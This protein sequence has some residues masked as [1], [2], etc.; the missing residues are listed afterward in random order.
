MNT[1]AGSRLADPRQIGLPRLPD[2]WMTLHEQYG[3]MFCF[4]FFQVEF[5][6]TFDLDAILYLIDSYV[7]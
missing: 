3:D 1:A 6:A 4:F 7:D 2:T 5:L